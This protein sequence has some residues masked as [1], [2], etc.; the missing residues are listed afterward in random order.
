[1]RTVLSCHAQLC[2]QESLA[3][4][5]GFRFLSSACALRIGTA[6]AFGSNSRF[7]PASTAPP[8]FLACPAPYFERAA[9]FPR[10]SHHLRSMRLAWCTAW[11]GSLGS[12]VC[13]LRVC[14]FVHRAWKNRMKNSGYFFSPGP[15][16]L[17]SHDSQDH[18]SYS[19]VML[20]ASPMHS[21]KHETRRDFSP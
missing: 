6:V 7:F 13:A 5:V 12:L 15:V 19:T 17:W 3:V 4:F 11:A 8:E 10:P 21:L 2:P 14:S 20:L 18:T 9:G 1:M 16:G